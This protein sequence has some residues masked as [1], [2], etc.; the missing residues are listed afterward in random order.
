MKQLLDKKHENKK[1]IIE[2]VPMNATTQRR[3]FA[4]ILIKTSANFRGIS[5]VKSDSHI[6]SSRIPLCHT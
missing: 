3:C 6:S 1:T 2:K 4:E 5:Y